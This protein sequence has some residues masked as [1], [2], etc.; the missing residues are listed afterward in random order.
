MMF[1]IFQLIPYAYRALEEKSEIEDIIKRL[2]PYE[3]LI[4]PLVNQIRR[5]SDLWP[6][7]LAVYNKFVGQTAPQLPS[8]E[9]IQGKLNLWGFA[10]AGSKLYIPLL[11]DGKYGEH[12][13]TVCE[14]FQQ[15]AGITVDGLFG[16]ETYD[17]MINWLQ[18]NEL[19]TS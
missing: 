8:V 15:S 10:T 16:P 13:Q 3:P 18:K 5:D 11:I 6:R 9:W 4:T 12:S 2:Q 7:I 1:N 19:P 17:A 14:R